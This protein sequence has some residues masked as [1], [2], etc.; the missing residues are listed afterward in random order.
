MG[1]LD[2]AVDKL[3]AEQTPE[4]AAQV[5]PS[6]PRA[7]RKERTSAEPRVASASDDAR[8][9][10]AVYGGEVDLDLAG[11]AAQGY[12]VPGFRCDGL[13]LDEYRRIKRQLLFKAAVDD[14][15]AE[16][17]RPSGNLIMVTSAVDGEGKTFV[18][19][20]LAFSVSLERDRSAL[21]IDGDVI[22]RGAS[23]LLG[24]EQHAGLIDYL[25]G[26]VDDLSE[27][28]VQP[29]GLEN[30][31]ILPTGAPHE[32]ANELL[33][34]ERMQDLLDELAQQH[35]DWVVV[36]DTPPLL[37]TSEATVLAQQMGQIALVV[38]ADITPQ[39]HVQNALDH[40]PADRLSGLILNAATRNLAQD[41][42]ADYYYGD[43]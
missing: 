4:T 18:S 11:L 36:M 3:K 8:R 20:N 35:P 37:M 24:L 13:L 40:I 42:Y 32:H 21:L 38:R 30:F 28:L 9:V 12:V 7:P 2:R 14:A 23:R 29:K 41:G 26:E 25:L 31:W 6:A 15:D 10:A 1:L 39:H 19:T 34:S 16:E 22:R 43:T 5:R 17:R 27:L 33:A